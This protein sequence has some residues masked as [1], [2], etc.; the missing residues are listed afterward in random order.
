VWLGGVVLVAWF[1]AYAA[2]AMLAASLLTPP[3]RRAAVTPGAAA[4][5][6]DGKEREMVALNARGVAT[7][8]GSGRAA[9]LTCI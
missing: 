3:A 2:G 4:A 1:L 9:G 7:G 8:P 5:E 6:E